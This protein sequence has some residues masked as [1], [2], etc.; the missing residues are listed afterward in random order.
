[1]K[2]LFSKHTSFGKHIH[3][4]YHA[5]GIQTVIGRISRFFFR[6]PQY[7]RFSILGAA[8]ITLCIV[9]IA[10]NTTPSLEELFIQYE[11]RNYTDTIEIAR[12]L[13][14]SDIQRPEVSFILARAY[15]KSGHPEQ[16]ASFYKNA[17]AARSAIQPYAQLRYAAQLVHA[18]KY[19]DAEKVFKSLRRNDNLYIALESSRLQALT[20][21]SNNNDA[22][23]ESF[24][25][26][27]M[28][29]FEK[30]KKV[31]PKRIFQITFSGTY[32]SELRMIAY[33]AAL[34]Q[35]KYS[36]AAQYAKEVIRRFKG[37]ADAR[38]SLDNLIALEKKTGIPYCASPEDSYTI[39]KTAL[40]LKRYTN[41][42]A[43]AATTLQK[44]TISD[45]LKYKALSVQYTAYLK[46]NKLSEAVKVA[47][48][49][50]KIPGKSFTARGIVMLATLKPRRESQT[51]YYEVI[52]KYPRTYAALDAAARLI[53]NNVKKSNYT[54][55]YRIAAAILTYH[56]DNTE[57]A[58]SALLAVLRIYEQKKYSDCI[59]QLITLSKYSS[60]APAALYR[61]GRSFE[62][63]KQPGEASSYYYMILSRHPDSFYYWPAMDRY[64]ECIAL[65]ADEKKESEATAHGLYSHKDWKQ[66]AYAY[67]KLF[68]SVSNS[69][70]QK[71]YRSAIRECLR[72]L[73]PYQLFY[74]TTIQP[75]NSKK[76]KDFK[77]VEMFYSAHESYYGEIALGVYSINNKYATQTNRL[78]RA[79]F[80]SLYGHTGR[81]VR[82]YEAM[83]WHLNDDPCLHFLPRSFITNLY[84]I[85]YSH[86][87]SLSCRR[88]NLDRRFVY[89][90]M[91]Q[92]SYYIPSVRSYANACGLMQVIPT[93]YSFI[94]KNNAFMKN[95]SDNIY[96]IE[97][98]IE[99]G[100][101]Y[102]GDMMK[103]FKRDITLTAMGYNAGPGRP[104]Q[105][106]KT[107]PSSDPYLLMEFV[108]LQQPRYYTKKVYY[109][110]RIYQMLYP[111]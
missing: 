8:V 63:I 107:F 45:T 85:P 36:N 66:A 65:T 26:T 50:K 97:Q 99:A 89:A 75:L 39:A 88:H 101:W 73:K 34:R 58:R 103:E 12:K 53:N 78:A 25:T 95:S 30:A 92:E 17:A 104:R 48:R 60:I 4:V 109:Y 47:Q 21:L 100:T 82:C 83:T 13:N 19:T 49:V 62:H 46:I 111:K 56:A 102:L 32:Y 57:L 68:Y 11:Q 55:A 67:M 24:I 1:M 27:A 7:V 64:R 69:H 84:P 18:G 28:E 5:M 72:K 96:D 44:H 10:M 2:T 91:R 86:Y 37:T 94:R 43:Y 98:N 29:L 70:D 16:A 93:T 80:Y 33:T 40:T 42:V 41:A 23:A 74:D 87:V 110:Y 6:N 14:I 20:A 108:P 61:L 105:W 71:R 3:T 9:I 90:I 31:F 59:P 106:R 77:A 38:K 51:L 79:R 52:K 35:N 22:A 15:E 54:E 81:A 76:N